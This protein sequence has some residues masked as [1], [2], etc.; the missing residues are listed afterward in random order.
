M[1]EHDER[2]KLIEDELEEMHLQNERKISNMVTSMQIPEVSPVK[3]YTISRTPS[4]TSKGTRY[5]EM[6][7]VVFSGSK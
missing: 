1:L 7:Q 5:V 2:I 4:L 6:P 3:E